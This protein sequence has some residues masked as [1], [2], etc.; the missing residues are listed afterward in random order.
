MDLSKVEASFYF[1]YQ[2]YRSLNLGLYPDKE[3]QCS[4]Y[5]LL[6][7]NQNIE[8]SV[9]SSVQGSVHRFFLVLITLA[10]SILNTIFQ[11]RELKIFCT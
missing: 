7:T 10:V 2:F 4:E 5:Y 6:M 8:F 3:E 11:V 9:S 1:T